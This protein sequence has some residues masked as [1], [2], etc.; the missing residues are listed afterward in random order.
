MVVVVDGAARAHLVEVHG[1]GP[2][3]VE[4]VQER[5]AAAG[6]VHAADVQQRHLHVEDH[7]VAA[8]EVAAGHQLH[9]RQVQRLHVTAFVFVCLSV[10]IE[11]FY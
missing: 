1:E 2:V 7:V 9:R 6:G 11:N 4:E 10:A 5:Q 8:V 3:A